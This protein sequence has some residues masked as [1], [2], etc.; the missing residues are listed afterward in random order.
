MAAVSSMICDHRDAKEGCQ[1]STKEAASLC[2]AERCNLTRKEPMWLFVLTDQVVAAYPSQL[3]EAASAA[4]TA[5]TR[6]TTA[7]TTTTAR[8][9]ASSPWTLVA[10]LTVAPRSGHQAIMV[11]DVLHIM[12]GTTRDEEGVL[13]AKSDKIKFSCAQD[14]CSKDIASTIKTTYSNTA[15]FR[16]NEA[17][18]PQIGDKSIA[19]VAVNSGNDHDDNVAVGGT[20]DADHAND[21]DDDVVVLLSTRPLVSMLAHESCCASAGVIGSLIYFAGTF[22]KMNKKKLVAI[23]SLSFGS[24]LNIQEAVLAI[25]MYPFLLLRLSVLIPDPSLGRDWLQCIKSDTMR[26]P[27]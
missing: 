4:A 11:D 6:A 9:S 22:S 10:P 20:D 19:L 2:L 5:T 7:P 24:H 27:R 1:R 8:Y 16:D 15:S 12:G 21:H 25:Y 18:G 23:H 3:I 14:K 26:V 13:C 17:L